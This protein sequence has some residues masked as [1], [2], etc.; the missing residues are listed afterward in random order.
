M[1]RMHE[2]DFTKDLMIGLILG[3]Q[4]DTVTQVKD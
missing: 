1:P 4:G 2:C 3:R